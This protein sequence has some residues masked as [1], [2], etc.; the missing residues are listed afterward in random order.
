[1]HFDEALHT[2]ARIISL[3]LKGDEYNDLRNMFTS[4][5]QLKMF[6]RDLRKIATCNQRNKIGNSAG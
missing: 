5:T 1:M 2:V 3:I 6:V 4:I